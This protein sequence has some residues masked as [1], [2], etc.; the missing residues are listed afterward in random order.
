[1]DPLLLSCRVLWSIHCSAVCQRHKRT[2]SFL[3]LTTH[4]PTQTAIFLCFDW[5]ITRIE[6][7]IFNPFERKNCLGTWSIVIGM[8]IMTIES[9]GFAYHQFAEALIGEES[10]E[11]TESFVPFFFVCR[12]KQ[13]LSCL[14]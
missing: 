5:L 13:P 6:V 1:M 3:S 9:L 7:S 2:F 12:S 11:E 10:P 8:T 4:P 14:T